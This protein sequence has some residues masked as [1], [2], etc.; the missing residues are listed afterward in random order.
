MIVI[1]TLDHASVFKNELLPEE[2]QA[3]VAAS[4]ENK[5]RKPAKTAGRKNKKVKTELPSEHIAN[6]NEKSDESPEASPTEVNKPKKETP[7]GSSTER[8]GITESCHRSELTADEK[9]WLVQR[10]VEIK[11]SGQKVSVPDLYQKYLAYASVPLSV[12]KNNYDA[13]RMRAATVLKKSRVV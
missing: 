3:P 9:E 2:E 6:A 5:K 11:Q 10:I 4:L 1:P 8:D 7:S 12:L 13:L